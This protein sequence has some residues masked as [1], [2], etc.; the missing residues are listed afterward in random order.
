LIELSDLIVGQLARRRPGVQPEIPE[1]FAL[2]DV[3]DAGADSLVEQ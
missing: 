2:V 1:R 3:A